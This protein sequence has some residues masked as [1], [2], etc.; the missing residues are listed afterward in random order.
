MSDQLRKKAKALLERGVFI[1]EDFSEK[2]LGELVEELRLHQAE[3]QLQNDELQESYDQLIRSRDRF[4]SLFHYAPVGYL[5]LDKTALILD[6]NQTFCEMVQKERTALLRNPFSELVAQQDV[7][8]FLSRYGAFYKNPDNKTIELELLVQG[9]TSIFANL[10][11][12]HLDSDQSEPSGQEQKSFLVVA[13]DITK[14]KQAEERERHA[15]NILR[16]VRSIGKI[17]TSEVDAQ[18]LIEMA[19]AKLTE[20]MGYHNA[21]IALFDEHEKQVVSIASAGFGSEFS[22]MK[23]RLLSGNYSSCMSRALTEGDL[24]VVQNPTSECSD[25]P[26]SQQYANCAG[27]VKRLEARRETFGILAVSVPWL[28]VGYQ[29][30]HDLFEEVVRDISFALSRIK[31]AQHYQRAHQIV[32]RSPAVAFVWEN[33]P[34]WPV[35]YVSQ[36]IERIFG[37]KAQQFVANELSYLDV[38]HPDDRVRV[39]HEVSSSSRSRSS[40]QVKH[41]PYRIK[42]PDGSFRWVDDRTF[43]QRD[44]RGEI[45]HYE[46]IVLDITEQ[47]RAEDIASSF[48]NQPLNLHLVSDIDGTIRRVNTAWCDHL[49]YE[50]EELAGKQFLDLVHPEDIASTVIEMERL[51]KG[52]P[53]LYFENNCLHKDGHYRLLAWSASISFDNTTVYAVAKDITERRHAEG[54][55]QQTTERLKQI[56]VLSSDYFYGLKIDASGELIIDWISESFETITSFS[57]DEIESFDDWLSHIHSDDVNQLKESLSVLLENQQVI[58]EYRVIK[59]NEETVWLEERLQPV[60]DPEIQSV[61]YVYGVAQDITA[62]KRLEINLQRLTEQQQT[63]FD[64]AMV[65]IMVVHN[66]VITSVNTR[67]AEMLGYLPEELSGSGT[68]LVFLSRDHFDD[69]GHRYYSRLKDEVIVQIEYPLRHKNGDT[70]LCLF[71]GQA[72]HPPDLSKGV[73]WIIDDITE[74]KESERRSFQ[75]RREESLSRLAGSVAHHFNNI[76]TATIGRLE[77]AKSGAMSAGH[78]LEHIKAAESAALRAAKLSQLMLT[79]LGQI[80]RKRQLIDPRQAWQPILEHFADTLPGSVTLNVENHE[81]DLAIEGDFELL[82]QVLEIVLE[83]ALESLEETDKGIIEVSIDVVEESEIT[84]KHRY[85]NYWYSSA[86]HFVRCMITDSGKGISEEKLDLVF[87]PFFSDKFTG[88]GLGLAVALGIVRSHGGYISVDSS[89]GKGTRFSLY[90]PICS[91]D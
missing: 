87:D 90:F 71:N 8:P 33:A 80:H 31:L 84:E 72:I 5:V 82:Q 16:A 6:V 18:H 12:R 62:R 49:G 15:H 36:N 51:A 11:G 48:F 43:I 54:A 29:E 27:F 42:R 69:F 25:C 45:T 67:M 2:E 70:I 19:C 17:I 38:I 86:R 14:Q 50:S 24:I 57:L 83:N 37:W 10:Q 39:G 32:E 21:W 34:G 55:L 59:K 77:L 9:R 79:Y 20:D 3:L 56:A 81:C 64:T 26:L 75:L 89:V 35:V 76:L 78:V 40:S 13:T 58:T 30:E 53:V 68:E 46:G 88:R 63:I 4:F 85:P 66:R 65:G 28:Y 7:S 41:L 74:R 73:V 22:L 52:Q 23:D 1:H 61:R 60:W 44:E 47:Q 91:H